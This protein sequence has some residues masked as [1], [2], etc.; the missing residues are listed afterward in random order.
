[1]PP[2]RKAP[3]TSALLVEAIQKLRN[4]HG[5]TSQEIT[6]Y[7]ASDCDGPKK[8]IRR[9]MK[10]ALRRGVSAGILHRSKEGYYTCAGFDTDP[11][12]R[13]RRGKCGKKPKR[14]RGCRRKRKSCGRRRRRK[15]RCGM[16][17]QRRR[18][19]SKRRRKRRK[20]CGGKSRSGAEGEDVNLDAVGTG[21][22]E[23]TPS[24]T[25]A[26]K[27]SQ[28]GNRSGNKSGKN[29]SNGSS[30]SG[31]SSASSGK[32]LGSGAGSAS[33]TRSGGPSRK[34][35]FSGQSDISGSSDGETGRK[36]Q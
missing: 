12:D 17:K 9:Q 16:K 22:R 3:K 36:E 2:V 11:A 28:R 34:E 7:I 18:C 15:M 14:S 27:K 1:M 29:V 13:S 30:H 4:I 21:H 25:L 10:L 31:I 5:S 33:A 35:S 20:S 32:T 23:G 19:G 8:T 6:N 24:V 26:A